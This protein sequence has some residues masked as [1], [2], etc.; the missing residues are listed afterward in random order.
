MAE[1]GHETRCPKQPCMGDCYVDDAG[2]TIHRSNCPQSRRC[3][4]ALI[5]AV[6]ADT[7]GEAIAA[8]KSMPSVATYSDAA[9]NNWL[10][11][12]IIQIDTVR[13]I[14]ALRTPTPDTENRTEAQA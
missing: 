5:R 10:Q 7:I 14:T 8:V 11:P 12:L 13:A 2:T 1:Q 6:R 9:S 3:Q 4:C